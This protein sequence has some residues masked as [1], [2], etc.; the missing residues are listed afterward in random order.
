MH[1][2]VI[3]GAGIRAILEDDPDLGI[4]RQQFQEFARSRGLDP[5]EVAPDL[6]DGVVP[7]QR[8]KKALKDRYGLE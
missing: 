2:L 3:P 7:Y 6:T 5:F 4:L 8:Q 1:V